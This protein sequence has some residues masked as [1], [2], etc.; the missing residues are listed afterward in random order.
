[1]KVHSE[2]ITSANTHRMYTVHTREWLVLISLIMMWAFL[3]WQEWKKCD[4]LHLNFVISTSTFQFLEMKIIILGIPCPGIIT[5]W[6]K[7]AIS[8]YWGIKKNSHLFTRFYYFAFKIH[9]ARNES[10]FQNVRW[11]TFSISFNISIHER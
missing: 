10:N 6:M 9:H 5:K 11:I 7:W 8:A 1:M 3:P 4:E 2:H